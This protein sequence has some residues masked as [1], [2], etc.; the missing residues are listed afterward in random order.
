M[1]VKLKLELALINEEFDCMCSKR[2]S[3]HH[4]TGLQQFM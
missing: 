4:A 3:F 2:I 1:F